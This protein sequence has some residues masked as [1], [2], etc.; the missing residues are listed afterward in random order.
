MKNNQTNGVSALFL[1]QAV[2]V[3]K[4]KRKYAQLRAQKEGSNPVHRG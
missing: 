2:A 4:E 3:Q 1:Y